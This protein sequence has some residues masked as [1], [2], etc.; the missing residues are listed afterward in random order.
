[1]ATQSA[2]G[3]RGHVSSTLEQ[4][5]HRE[6]VLGTHSRSGSQWDIWEAVY[7][8]VG[9]DGYPERLWDKRTGEIDHAVAEHW[10]ENYDL[11]HIL[12]RDWKVLGAKLAGKIHLYCG[13]MDNYYLNNAVYLME[14]FLE[15]T[16]DPHYGGEVDYGHLA[17]LC[18]NCDHERPNAISRLRYHV[19]YVDKILE[20]IAR[21][22]PPGADVTSW[23]Y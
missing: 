8:P 9:S 22:A 1:M 6:L 4:M 21:T 20:R 15:S 16:K 17:E 5:N 14:E 23:R 13:T 18:W 7:S 10:R 12:Q 3:T 11:R 19:M 2:C